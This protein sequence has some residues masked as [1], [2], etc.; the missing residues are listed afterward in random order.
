MIIYDIDSLSAV[1][2]KIY[3]NLLKLTL[4]PRKGS[5]YQIAKEKSTSPFCYAVDKEVNKIIGWSM[6]MDSKSIEKDNEIKK[7]AY[8]GV[9]VKPEYRKKGI[10][11]N[12]IKNLGELLKSIYDY[13]V[14]VAHDGQ[15]YN[16][17]KKIGTI[18][19]KNAPEDDWDVI[20]NRRIIPLKNKK[21][22]NPLKEGRK[23]DR[24]NKILDTIIGLINDS[25]DVI[26][27]QTAEKHHDLLNWIG[28]DKGFIDSDKGWRYHK[29][30]GIVR[31]WVGDLPNQTEKNLVEEFLESQYNIKKVK[32]HATYSM[33]PKSLKETNDNRLVHQVKQL[34]MECIKERK[35]Q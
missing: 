27:S 12:L 34:I 16:F 13:I 18:P 20:Y 23:I 2:K 29:D 1:D 30:D 24:G 15:S 3:R 21:K 8:L 31:W 10:G 14:M 32:G 5:M 6:I 22:E 26:G 35:N 28:R 9:Y 25:G 33:N 17:F 4:G 19:W 11:K 7:I